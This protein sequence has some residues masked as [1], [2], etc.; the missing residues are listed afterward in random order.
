MGATRLVC[1]FRIENSEL[2]WVRYTDSYMAFPPR[3]QPRAARFYQDFLDF[4]DGWNRELKGIMA[5]S[6]PDRRI[7]DMSRHSLV[8][9]LMTRMELRPKH[10]VVD[11]NYGHTQHDGFPDTF[12][13]ETLAMLEWGAP[14]IARRYIANYLERWVR[15]DG[16]IVHRGPEVGQYG[17]MLTNLAQYADYAGDYDVLLK[18]RTRID[19]IVKILLLLR[20][21][22]V[23]LDKGDPRHGLISG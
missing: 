13:A 4:R 6:L 22:A 12:N 9:V 17:R 14:H 20:E 23:R 10:G 18:Y 21:R 3:G 16:S 5:V 19:G 11:Q 7:E 8:R 2:K 1:V 15:D